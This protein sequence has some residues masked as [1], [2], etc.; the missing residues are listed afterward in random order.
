MSRSTVR[1][2][3]RILEVQGL[4]RIK[5]GRS[6]GAFVQRPGGESVASSVSLLIRGRQVRMA[7]LLETRE[8]IEPACAQLAAKYRTDDELRRYLSD[9]ADHATTAAERVGGFRVTLADILTLNATLVSQAQNEEVK[10]LSE[11][12]IA[13]NEEIK[14]ISAWAA[15]LFAPTLI[16]TIYGMNFQHMPELHWLL[17]YPFALLLMAAVCTVLYLAFRRRNWL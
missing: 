14:K 6:G 2:A 1:E 3:L 10:R 5:T 11:A 7:A 12:S 9:V 8:A 16:G 4:V 17:G 13:Q 15:I